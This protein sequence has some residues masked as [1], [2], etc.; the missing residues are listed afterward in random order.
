MIEPRKPT[1]L[2][3]DDRGD[4]DCGIVGDAIE[5]ATLW[6]AA[7]SSNVKPMAL[8]LFFRGDSSD[9]ASVSRSTIRVGMMLS[10]LFRFLVGGLC[11]QDEIL[12]DVG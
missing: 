1:I 5:D 4:C 2:R 7:S 8:P 6:I 11:S 9:G 3:D 10:F 12:L